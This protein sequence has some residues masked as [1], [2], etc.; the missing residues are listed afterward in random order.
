MFSRTYFPKAVSHF[1]GYVLKG[2][3]MMNWVFVL[4]GVIAIGLAGLA[5]A[6]ILRH[7]R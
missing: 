3:A 2:N 6:V 5:I 1:S 4:Q 7:R